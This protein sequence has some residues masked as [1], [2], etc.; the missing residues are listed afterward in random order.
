MTLL[1]DLF[2]LVRVFVTMMLISTVVWT[3]GCTYIEFMCTSM[4]ETAALSYISLWFSSV[5][6]ALAG[7]MSL[8]AE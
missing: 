2:T 1:Q 8:E 7:C 6:F 3:L 5:L 4:T